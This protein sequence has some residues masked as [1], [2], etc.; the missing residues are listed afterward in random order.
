MEVEVIGAKDLPVEK[1]SR[2]EPTY[3][4]FNFFDGTEAETPSLVGA[5]KLLWSHKHV[6]LAGLMNPVELK[7]K[8]RSRYLKFELHDR[9]EIANRKAKPD[10]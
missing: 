3:V 7:E 2:Y 8:M 10:I 1:S 9:D 5:D 4:K 6:F